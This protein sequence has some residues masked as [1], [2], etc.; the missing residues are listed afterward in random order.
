MQIQSNALTT[1]CKTMGQT[2]AII[3][4]HEGEQQHGDTH[5]EDGQNNGNT[6]QYGNK[7]FALAALKEH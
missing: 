1:F 2:P 7:M 4:S 5:T 3:Y 6:R